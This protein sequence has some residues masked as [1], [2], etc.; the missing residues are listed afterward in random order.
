V[1]ALVAG[2]AGA[3][4]QVQA[5][6]DS[7]VSGTGAGFMVAAA[8]APPAAMLGLS[9][10]LARWDYAGLMAFLLLLQFVAISLGGWLVLL[11]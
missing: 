5:E 1:L 2:A 6:R 3:Q 7:L 10:P 11:G 8:L 9:V 4:A